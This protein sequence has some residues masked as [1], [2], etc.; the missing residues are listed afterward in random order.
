MHFDGY[1]IKFCA[2]K[3][4]EN[5]VNKFR[6]WYWNVAGKF[7]WFVYI[8]ECAWVSQYNPIFLWSFCSFLNWRLFLEHC[9]MYS[10]PQRKSIKYKNQTEQQQQQMHTSAV[11]KIAWQLQCLRFIVINL[12]CS[13][14]SF[15]KVEDE[16]KRIISLSFDRNRFWLEKKEIHRTKYDFYDRRGHW[17]CIDAPLILLCSVSLCVRANLFIF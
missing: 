5:C 17:K 1:K 15:I 7:I 11:W 4:A 14:H 3:N 6:F 16:K 9:K 12:W 2:T 8:N 10:S 13:K